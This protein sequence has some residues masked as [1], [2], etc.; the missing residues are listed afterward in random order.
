MA[1][2]RT[3]TRTFSV[4]VPPERV[5]K[6]MTD[7]AEMEKWFFGLTPAPREGRAGDSG[8]QFDMYGTPTEIELLEVERLRKLRYAENTGRGERIGRAEVAVTFEDEAAGTRITV[9]RSGFGDGSH[10]DGVI[11][12]N[13]RGLEE[14]FADL[15]LY[16]ETGVSYPRHQRQLIHPGFSG[17]ETHGGLLVRS[18]EAGSFAAEVGLHAGDVIVELGGAAVFGHR[19]LIFGLRS[20]QTGDHVEVGW[21]RGGELVHGKAVIPVWT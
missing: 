14:T 6:A 7:P 2:S 8:G 4:A 10:W 20:H 12:Q 11:E 9:T 13:G 18:V 16:L 19:E 5:W 15:I 1:D 17:T 3:V 21:V